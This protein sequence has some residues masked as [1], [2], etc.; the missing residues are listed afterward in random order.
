MYNFAEGEII[1]INKPT[2]WSSF[3]VVRK[4]RSVIRFKKIG[5]AGTLDPLASGLLILATGKKTKTISSLQATTKEYIGTITLGGTT[6]CFDLELPIDK[7]YP[8]EHITGELIYATAQTFTGEQW[9]YPPIYSAVKQDGKR[10]YKSAREQEEIEIKKRQV[11]ISAFEITK[12][13]MPVVHFRVVCS[14]G[15]YIRSL[16]NDF[17][18]AMNSGSHLSSLCRTKSG[19]I[20]L[21]QA[22]ELDKWVEDFK[23]LQ[24]NEATLK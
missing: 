23:N 12:I 5:H 11:V 19:D 20:S 24:Q 21:A 7:T 15:T 18:K 8:T 6:P 17:G 10:L 13:E 22:T 9:Q 3:D 16:A 1:I 14:S 4:I 2:R